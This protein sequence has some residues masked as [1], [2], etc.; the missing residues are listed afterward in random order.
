MLPCNSDDEVDDHVWKYTTYQQF[1]HQQS[2]LCIDRKN[3]DKNYVHAA[4]CDSHSPTQKFEF[5][6]NEKD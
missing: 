3:L 4:V 1:K 6:K 2:G 5:Q